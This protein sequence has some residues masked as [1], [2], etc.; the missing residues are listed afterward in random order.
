MRVYICEVWHPRMGVAG[1]WLPAEDAQWGT[2]DDAID[3]AL[4]CER[5]GYIV[6][7]KGRNTSRARAN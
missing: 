7:I 6:R 2:C 4:A 3:D 5:A 1:K